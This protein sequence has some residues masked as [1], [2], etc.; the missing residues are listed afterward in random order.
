M[1]SAGIDNL[2]D[3]VP[4]RAGTP[5]MPRSVRRNP[6]STETD[7]NNNNEKRKRCNV[8]NF[9]FFL[10]LRRSRTDTLGGGRY[11]YLYNNNIKYYVRRSCQK[12]RLPPPHRRLYGRGVR[13]AQSNRAGACNQIRPRG[14]YSDVADVGREPSA[15]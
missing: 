4:T 10:I 2:P 12:T 5:T 3:G 8:C 11:T 14:G 6:F 7:K 1:A 9:Y 15:F 13:V